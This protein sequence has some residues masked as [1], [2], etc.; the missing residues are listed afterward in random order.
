[1]IVISGSSGFIGGNLKKDIDSSVGVSLRV[2][3]WEKQFEEA[4]IIINLVGKAHDHNKTATVDDYTF[5]N[6]QLAKKVF[7]AFIDSS[8]TLLIH[9]S[10][11]A[12]IEEYESKVPLKEA[13]PCAPISLYGQS[14]REAEVWLLEQKLPENKKLIILRPPMV[15]G[16]GDKGNL[17]FLYKLVARGIPYPLA[18]Y[19]NQRSFISIDNFS[20]FLKKIIE[21]QE[22]ISSGI[23]HIADDEPISTNMIIGVMKEVTGKKGFNLAIP[24]ILVN[25]IAKVGD[26]LPIPLNSIRLKKMTSTLLVSNTKI[27]RV[28]EI[29]A[30][31]KTTEEGMYTTIKSFQED[32]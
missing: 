15:H 24:K 10:S 21:N 31:P 12:A 4:S 9:I 16:P 5:A 7:R 25:G 2:N 20:F 23:Y 27:K 32:K 28:L 8:A 18:A 26:T 14:K 3:N 11:L 29:D 30:L 22:K 13:D 17:N 1:M 6:V 19:N